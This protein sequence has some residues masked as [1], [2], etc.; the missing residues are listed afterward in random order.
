V[1][2]LVLSCYSFVCSQHPHL[3][4]FVT[5]TRQHDANLGM[6]CRLGFLGVVGAA[7]RT[8]ECRWSRFLERASEAVALRRHFP[9]ITLDGI[10]SKIGMFFVGLR[11]LE[12]SRSHS[13]SMK[14]NGSKRCYWTEIIRFVLGLLLQS[15]RRRVV[16][17]TEAVNLTERPAAFSCLVFRPRCSSSSWRL[18]LH[19]TSHGLSSPLST[20]LE[21]ALSSKRTSTSSPASH[22]WHSMWR[23]VNVCGTRLNVPHF[24]DMDRPLILR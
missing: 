20:S 12:P 9:G 24:Y 14:F 18:R 15:M 11:L 7:I 10:P 2:C 19:N 23:C 17:V 22:R 1:S 6:Y 16:V 13:R 3:Q 4:A 21:V 5:S 8:S